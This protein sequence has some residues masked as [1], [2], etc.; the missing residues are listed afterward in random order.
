[1]PHVIVLVLFCL[2]TAAASAGKV[3]TYASP[4]LD[5]DSVNTHLIPTPAGL[6]VFDAQR[7]LPEAE[8]VVR[9]IGDRPV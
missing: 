6:I 2:F 9:L 8:R 1:M 5:V 4:A 7:L 3:Q